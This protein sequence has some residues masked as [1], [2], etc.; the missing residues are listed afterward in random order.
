MAKSGD[1]ERAATKVDPDFRVWDGVYGTFAEAP[2]AGPGFAGPIW[3]DRSLAA[4][5][6]T[7]AAA[8]MGQPLDYALRQRNA[9]LPPVTA[10]TL[11]GQ[12]RANIL[13]FG[14]G[15]GTGYLVLDKAM[16]DTVA[17]IDYTIVEGEGICRAGR[18][19][20]A[21]ANN[22]PSF[23][24]ELPASARFDI[25]HAASVIQYI[26]DWRHL[27]RKLAGYGA[28][29]LS[30]ADIFI[31]EFSTYVTLQNYYDSRIRH[32]FFNAAEFIGE[33]ERN[34]YQLAMRAEC[35]GMILGQYGP[36]PMAN[37]T[38]VLRL[39]HT[40]NLLFRKPSARR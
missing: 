32:W 1:P 16:S 4:A 9:V 29:L 10:L 40:S 37:F 31:G 6:D 34:G 27:I 24:S 28:P 7:L 35:D 8:Q 14:G 36:L 20:F 15:L 13:D 19:L 2:A 39:A 23:R 30:L 22:Q 25:V 3:R 26:E 12:Q 17:R 21:G 18:D 5:R 11:A 38:P 33:V